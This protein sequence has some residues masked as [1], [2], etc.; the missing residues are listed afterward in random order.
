[1]LNF[2]VSSKLN[3]DQYTLKLVEI[4]RNTSIELKD[5][6]KKIIRAD[7]IDLFDEFGMRSLV[8]FQ[9]A[10]THNLL[11]KDDIYFLLIIFKALQN[12]DFDD[13]K[14]ISKLINL[15][16]CKPDLVEPFKESFICFLCEEITVWASEGYD[17]E[18]IYYESDIED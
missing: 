9:L 1:M 14:E 2:E 16:D 18:D 15:L 12:A 6:I 3:I 13:F 5:I 7:P 4:S 10:V 17:F 11:D 8:V